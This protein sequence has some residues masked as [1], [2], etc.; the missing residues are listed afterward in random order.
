MWSAVPFAL[1]FDE[2]YLCWQGPTIFG[3]P[4]F[5]G[6]PWKLFFSCQD[7][8]QEAGIWR[9]SLQIQ[10]CLLPR[11]CSRG[12]ILKPALANSI[13]FLRL[14]R[15]QGGPNSKDV[16]ANSMSLRVKMMSKMMPKRPEFEG[17]PCKFKVFLLSRLPLA[18]LG[19]ARG[20]LTGTFFRA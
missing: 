12:L 18:L 11:W 10:W 3:R 14:R 15:C 1:F 7:D 17:R 4:P 13:F 5:E 2:L 16:L 20:N 6:F 19:S 9:T 8:V